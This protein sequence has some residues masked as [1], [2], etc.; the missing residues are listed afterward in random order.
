MVNAVVPIL[1]DC[2]DPKRLVSDMKPGD[3][4]SWAIIRYVWV[5]RDDGG[6]ALPDISNRK[7]R[8]MVGCFMLALGDDEQ[9]AETAT[10]NYR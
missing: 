4:I 3:C 2:N 1:A 7:Q 8:I 6:P 9:T 10:L 5:H